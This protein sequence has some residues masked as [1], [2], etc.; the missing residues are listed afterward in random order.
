[1]LLEDE[2][3]LHEYPSIEIRNPCHW[4][5]TDAFSSQ[6]YS[7]LMRF[8]NEMYISMYG[9]I[10]NNESQEPKCTNGTQRS[11]SFSPTFLR[12]PATAL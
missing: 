4:N 9:N 8:Y 3:S 12:S 10:S 5:K 6:R 2:I 11:N 7:S 1:M